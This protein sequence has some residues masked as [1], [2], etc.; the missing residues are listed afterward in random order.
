MTYNFTS[1]QQIAV[2]LVGA[3]FAASLSISAAV[4]PVA[5]FI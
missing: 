3:I 2:S 1:L 4:G 5:Q